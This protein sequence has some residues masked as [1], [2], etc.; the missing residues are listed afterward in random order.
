MTLQR[1]NYG[2][3]LA[4]VRVVDLSRGISG[5]FCGHALAQLGAD[6][7]AVRPSASALAGQEVIQQRSLDRCKRAVSF[8]CYD[9]DEFCR[10]ENLCAGAD[11]VIEDRPAAGWPSGQPIAALLL[12]KVPRLTSICLSPFGLAGPH[13]SYAAE[14]LNIYHSAGHAKQ[15]PCD[16]LWQDYKSRPPLQAGGYWG[17]AQSGLL[18]AVVA[19]AIVS[20]NGTWRGRIVDCSKQEALLQMHWTELVRYPNSGRLVDRLK[21]SITFVGGMLPALDGYIQVVCLEQ[22]QWSGLVKLLG[23]PDWMLSAD[24]ASPALRVMHWAE[25]AE[26]L[27]IETRKRNRQDLFINGQAL[28]VPIAPVMRLAELR[29]DER[30]HQ[31]GV[32]DA[33]NPDGSLTPRWDGA[34]YV[35]SAP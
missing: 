31:R 32:F 26:R 30:L 10:L 17:E 12:S 28:G 15:I 18:A 7:V 23:D 13:S 11:L 14:P 34:V 29:V 24:Y 33:R 5:A 21:P 8:D 9:A 6:V 25:I 1:T 3:V 27:A 22:H 2:H 20:G 35:D 4:D 19:M 16:A